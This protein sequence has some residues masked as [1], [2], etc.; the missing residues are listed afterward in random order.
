MA[1]FHLPIL[2][3][4]SQSS[5][6]F[7][8]PSFSHSL[9]LSLLLIFI[10][11]FSFASVSPLH[12]GLFLNCCCRCSCRCSCRCCCCCC[13]WLLLAFSSLHHVWVSGYRDFQLCLVS[14]EYQEAASQ[15]QKHWYALRILKYNSSTLRSTSCC[16]YSC[17]LVS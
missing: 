9:S 3:L 17:C 1:S 16:Y 4:F 14:Q 2:R 15:N 13:C 11:C 12:L 6:L 7:V 8:S 10:I 5:S